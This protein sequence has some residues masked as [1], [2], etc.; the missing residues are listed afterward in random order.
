MI[1]RSVSIPTL[2]KPN[3][4][5]ILYGPRQVGKTTLVRHYLSQAPEFPGGVIEKTGDDIP[6]ANTL[7]QCDLHYLRSTIAPE[8]LLVIDE[9]QRIPNIGRALKL[10]ID[11]IAGVQ[12]IVTGSSSF[13]LLQST[14]ESLTGRKTVA[15]LFP[16]SV[17]EALSQVSR[18]DLP[19]LLP[20]YVRFGMYPAVLTAKT[21]QEKEAII[22]ELAGS[23][24]LKDIL[25]FDKIKNS[26]KIFDVLRLLAFQVGSQVSIQEIGTSV[27]VDKN[28][29]ARYLDLLEK[30][31]VLYRLD[32]FSR[33]LRKEVSKMSKYYF[34]DLGIRNALIANFNPLELRND[35][36]QLWENFLVMERVKHQAYSGVSG[37]NYFWRTYDKKE[38]D[39]VEESG[40]ELH[41]YKFKWGKTKAS[42]P[43][44]WLETYAEADFRVIHPDNYLDFIT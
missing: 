25:D 38:L 14:G 40:G 4:V 8:S 26:S 36:G 37:N 5:L 20:D 42:P 11:N 30:S 6:F 27:G 10:I 7:A 12:V 21:Y 43:R 23:Y 2:L 34:F 16:V 39:W 17:Q 1:F 35:L 13:D 31:F 29:V 18:F 22:R 28:T 41:G 3:K 44:G 24:L 15:T 9:A 19:R 33:N 32:G